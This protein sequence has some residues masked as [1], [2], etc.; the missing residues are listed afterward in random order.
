[1]H[2]GLSMS[3]KERFCRS[4]VA[5]FAHRN[6]V[7]TNTSFS[8]LLNR[9]AFC[10]LLWAIKRGFPF[11]NRM[12]GVTIW[13]AFDLFE[14]ELEI[15]WLSLSF[16]AYAEKTMGLL[17]QIVQGWPNTLSEFHTT[18]WFKKM[19]SISWVYIS[20]TIHGMWMIYITFER[21]GPKF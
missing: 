13:I 19:D 16:Q 4:K 8:I 21:G 1:M 15:R 11:V 9:F 10:I 18:A 3:S 5:M 6:P 20:W 14:L 12:S 17:Q 2:I 7:T